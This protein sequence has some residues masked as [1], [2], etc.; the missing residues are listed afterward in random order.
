VLRQAESWTS[1]ESGFNPR[2]RPALSIVPEALRPGVKRT[3]RELTTHL[4]LVPKLRIRGDIPPLSDH[5]GR[6][7]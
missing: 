2:P 3:G 7:F 1:V 6:A 4:H 5:S